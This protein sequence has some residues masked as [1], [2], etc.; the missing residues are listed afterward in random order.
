MKN[1]IVQINIT[2]K[3]YADP[4]FNGLLQS[5]LNKYSIHSV[6]EYCKKYQIDHVVITEPKIKSKHPVFERFDLILNNDWWDRYDQILHLDT[7]IIISPHAINFFAE[8][9]DVDTMKVAVYPKYQKADLAWWKKEINRKVLYRKLDPKECKKR[10]FQTGVFCLTKSSAN[11]LRLYIKHFRLLD[12]YDDGK[13][14]NWAFIKS[15]VPYKKISN[16]WNYK[17]T[18]QPIP[19]L[20]AKYF[21]HA[22]GGK[23]HNPNSYIMKYCTKRWPNL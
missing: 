7:D 3:T 19:D 16:A 22:A 1:A 10:F 20:K 17:L 11:I 4:S 5:S 21:I 14:L 6:S 8:F 13:I 12:S 23:K 18:D 2:P 15:M 9:D